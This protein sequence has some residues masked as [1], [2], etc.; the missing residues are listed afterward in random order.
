MTTLYPERE[1][2]HHD[3]TFDVPPGVHEIE[4]D[5]DE[6]PAPHA[7]VTGEPIDE[8]PEAGR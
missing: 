8:T 4:P 6:T 1:P 3:V 7:D 5:G 2:E